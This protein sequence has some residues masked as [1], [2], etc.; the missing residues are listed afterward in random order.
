M[1]PLKKEFPNDELINNKL[2]DNQIVIT[3]M[4]MMTLLLKCSKYMGH[5]VVD[6]KKLLPI[7]SK[8]MRKSWCGTSSQEK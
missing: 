6:L 2:I 1:L 3:L 5:L 8:R 7:P 4:A